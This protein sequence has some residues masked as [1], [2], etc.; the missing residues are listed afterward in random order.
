MQFVIIQLILYLSRKAEHSA[1]C[2]NVSAL[3]VNAWEQ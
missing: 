2:M 1:I 3:H